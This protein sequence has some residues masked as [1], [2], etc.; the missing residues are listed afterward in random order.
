V[1]FLWSG[2]LQDEDILDTPRPVV[3][4]EGPRALFPL[5]AGAASEPDVTVLSH[6]EAGYNLRLTSGMG[7]EVWMDGRRQHVR[8][9]ARTGR[10]IP[11]G[12]GD[13]GVVTLGTVAV[14]FQ[15]VR[16]VRPLPRPYFG[17][18]DG[19]L[20]AAI[21]LSVFLFTSLLSLMY[22]A[23]DEFADP[24]P[25]ELPSDLL[26]RFLV[27]PPPESLTE[28][29]HAH[30][31]EAAD[32][33]PEARDEGEG[34]RHRGEEGRVGRQDS[35]EDR[36]DATGPI[37]GVDARVR[38]HSLLRALSQDGAIAAALSGPSVNDVLGGLD[39]LR[40]V[41]PRGS[42]GFGLTGYGDGGGGDEDGDL[43]GT[44][45]DVD[46]NSNPDRSDVASM[47]RGRG[48]RQIDV[49]LG[50]PLIPNDYLSPRQINRVVRANRAAI[51]YCYEVQVQR[52]RNL[53]GNVAI[54][55]RIGMTGAVTSARVARS[56]LNNP[57]VEGC[58]VRQIRRWRFPEPHGGE[59]VVT[60]PFMLG[61][62][63]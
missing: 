43:M 29:Q 13:Y 14:F 11:V 37:G 22:M 27:T 55:W 28:E 39:G 20:A 56:T 35:N 34:R 6:D 18:A 45:D 9:L 16:A 50:D 5:P 54:Q 30:S 47:R 8:D 26:A 63:G 2:T 49:D 25:L 36:L 3:L 57:S 4:G 51:R 44:G 7:G 48:E 40:D 32:P 12:P 15:Y 10:E 19:P 31:A 24:E 62:D 23:S 61:L 21:A 33:A 52:Q 60:Y 42:N 1:A 46:T 53:H 38:E 58:M 59:V 41:T 17:D